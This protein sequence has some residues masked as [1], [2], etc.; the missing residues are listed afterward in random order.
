MTVKTHEIETNEI[1]LTNTKKQLEKEE[2]R[3]AE[4]KNQDQQDSG[5]ETPKTRSELALENLKNQQSLANN[6]FTKK[7]R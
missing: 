1:K 5:W 7:F 6:P 3:L 2:K 4:L